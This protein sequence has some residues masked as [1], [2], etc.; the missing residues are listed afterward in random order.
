MV[1]RKGGT[2]TLAPTA[3]LVSLCCELELI[4]RLAGPE[5]LMWIKLAATWLE[6]LRFSI[7]LA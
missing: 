3:R 6:I 4:T 2:D 1:E 7:R 5:D